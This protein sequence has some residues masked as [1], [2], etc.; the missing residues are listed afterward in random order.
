MVKKSKM[1]KFLR[2]SW[3]RYSKL[4]KK[5]KKKRKWRRPTGRDNKMK[6]KRRGYSAVVSI[7]YG[8]KKELK[9]K[10]AGKKP[11]FVRNLNDLKKIS[12]NEIAIIGKVGARKK[13]EIIKKAEEMKIEIFNINAK[14]FLKEYERRK[15]LGKIK[16]ESK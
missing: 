4:G 6:E 16:N 13:I 1:I 9:Q 11:I 12:K 15:S 14:K 3:D 5:N 8:T 2:R 7:G 10:F